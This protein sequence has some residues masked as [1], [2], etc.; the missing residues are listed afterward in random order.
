M[1]K[2]GAEA[3]ERVELRRDDEAVGEEGG[4]EGGE[5]AHRLEWPHQILPERGLKEPIDWKSVFIANLTQSNSRIQT[6]LK[7]ELV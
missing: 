4:L 6:P 7:L 1:E 5:G 2:H 3:V